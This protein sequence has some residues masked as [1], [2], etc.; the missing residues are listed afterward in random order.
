MGNTQIVG[1]YNSRKREQEKTQRKLIEAKRVKAS[2]LKA[3]KDKVCELIRLIFKDQPRYRRRT[4]DEIIKAHA[5][6]LDMAVLGGEDFENT[7]QVLQWAYHNP[8]CYKEACMAMWP[9]LA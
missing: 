8:E 9:E 4:K 7:I 5:V 1:S 2:A 3:R 6:G